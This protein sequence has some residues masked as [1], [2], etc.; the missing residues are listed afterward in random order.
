[1]ARHLPALLLAISTLLLSVSADSSVHTMSKYHQLITSTTLNW[2]PHTHYTATSEEIV[3]GSF[4]DSSKTIYVCRALHNGIYVTGSMKDVE[5]G[6]LVT[7]LSIVKLYTKYDLLQNIDSAARVSWVYWDKYKE[8]PVGAVSPSNAE[9][10]FVARHIVDGV[11]S[12]FDAYEQMHFIGTLNTKDGLGKITYTKKDGTEGSTESGQI[13]VETEPFSYALNSVK[14]NFIKKREKKRE[15]RML[16]TATLTNTGSEAGKVD[17]AFTYSYNYTQY[18]GQGHAILKGLNTS[19]TL[20]NKTKLPDIVWGIPES[21]VQV[22]VKTVEYFLEP[23]TGV[24]VTLLGNY[25]DLEV[26]FSA[27]LVAVYDDGADKVRSISGVRQEETMLDVRPIFSPV[28]FLNNNSLVPTTV[29]P[30]TTTSTTTTTTTTTSTTT[31][32]GP[33][34][35]IMTK[36]MAKMESSNSEKED[37][38]MIIP[39]RK[40]D[41]NMQ[42]DDGGPL[43]LKNKIDGDH[44]M[45]NICL[46]NLLTITITIVISYI[47]IT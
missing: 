13:L 34:S 43:S 45:S 2:L 37:E 18:W 32:I 22:D 19:I 10:Y 12:Q 33:E 31:T 46:P 39:P 42:N 27:K 21:K 20:L 14:L 44:S 29:P 23:G 38:N 1:M 47:R 8:I 26:P 16:G 9:N 17:E 15:R 40:G 36:D 11:N 35:I 4:E 41:G 3:I 5:E 28:F 7:S 24:N 30:P 6:C 25:T